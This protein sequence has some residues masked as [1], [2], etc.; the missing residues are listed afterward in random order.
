MG[1]FESLGSLQDV[2]HG[3]IHRQPAALPYLELQIPTVDV[4]HH[5]VMRTI[6]IAGVV[7]RHD[8]GMLQAGQRTRFAQKP[9]FRLRRKRR[10]GGKQLE[11]HHAPHASVF[12]PEHVAHAARAERIENHIIADDEPLRAG[13]AQH[14][15]LIFGQLAQP[16]K[17]PRQQDSVGHGRHGN[18]SPAQHVDLV[19]GHQTAGAERVDELFDG[20]GHNDV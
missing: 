6:A 14:A 16:H 8:V 15:R 10:R 5:Q 18:N 20:K 9:L 12:G 19:A 13:A 3:P 1:V 7:R 11:R 2:I 4:L 17:F